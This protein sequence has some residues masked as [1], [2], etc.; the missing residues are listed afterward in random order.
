[1]SPFNRSDLI[2]ERQ[3][4]NKLRYSRSIPSFG[5][6]LPPEK[7]FMF[8]VILQPISGSKR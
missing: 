6:L 7:N 3:E 4:K 5:V 2:G 8:L 1:M